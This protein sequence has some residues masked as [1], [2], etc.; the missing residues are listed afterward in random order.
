MPSEHA[1]SQAII[2][3]GAQHNKF[4]NGSGRIAHIC[5]LLSGISQTKGLD[6]HDNADK[7]CLK[8][9][10][11]APSSCVSCSSV[12]SSLC[13]HDRVS[14][15]VMR[16][17]CGLLAPEKALV[18]VNRGP[19]GERGKERGWRTRGGGGKWQEKARREPAAT[20]MAPLPPP[21]S[22][23]VPLFPGRGASITALTAAPWVGS[24][25]FSFT[26][27]LRGLILKPLKALMCHNWQPSENTGEEEL[28]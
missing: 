15:A 21:L 22:P 24:R 7:K 11:W 2:T 8:G 25:V 4:S 19:R 27:G 12:S 23:G 16:V 18:G 14:V 1:E 17:V 5:E 20:E 3:F 13:L 6:D 28:K 26:C 10:L 9:S